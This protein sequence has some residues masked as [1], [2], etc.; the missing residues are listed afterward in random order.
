MIWLIGNRG[1]LGSDVEKLLKNKKFEYIATDVEIDITRYGVL[2]EYVEDKNIEWIINCAAYTAVDKAEDERELAYKI[3]AT[4]AENLAR[5]CKDIGSKLI[6]ISTDYVFDGQKDG[7]YTE[8][9]IPNPINVYGKSKL[10][11]EGRIK[12]ILKNY[13]ILRTS[14]LYG[15]NGN[16]FVHTMIRLFNQKD[17]IGVVSDQWGTPTYTKDLSNVILRIVE[18]DNNAFGIYHF[19]NAGVR[20][21]SDKNVEVGITWYD[22]AEK[23][24][25]VSKECGIIN[26]DVKIRPIKTEDYPTKAKRPQN[27]LLSKEKIKKTFDMEIRS[28]QEA[29]KDFIINDLS[30]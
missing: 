12:S 14:W 11:G 27:S 9:D 30:S 15:K 23:I 22:F 1:M 26:S 6:H 7:A 5:I 18:L 16:N 28:W 4:G 25:R 19:S 8:D 21:E 17:E 24:Y 3:N 13:Y 20:A 2:K 29:L 10:E